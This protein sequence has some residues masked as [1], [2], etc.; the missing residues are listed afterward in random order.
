MY[1]QYSVVKKVKNSVSDP[2]PGFFAD[3]DPDFKPRIRPIFGRSGSGLGKKF[4]PDPDKR[5]RIRDT[6]EKLI[7]QG[8]LM[9]KTVHIYMYTIY[10]Y[11]I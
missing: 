9:C 1:I 2:D 8:L 3:P 6:C 7:R 10:L 4:D 5:T 11:T